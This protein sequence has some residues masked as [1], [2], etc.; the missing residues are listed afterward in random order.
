MRLQ[1]GLTS[2]DPP[3]ISNMKFAIPAKMRFHTS[4]Q[5]TP[6]EL[7]SLE[8]MR[9]KPFHTA[10][11]TA[12]TFLLVGCASVPSGVE[13]GREGTIAYQVQIES[14]D[15]GARVEANGDYVG[16]TPM[17]LKIFG[18]KDGTFHNF[19]TDDYVIR[20]YPLKPGQHPQARSFRTGRWFSQEDR[21][22]GRLYFDLNEK[23]EG[24]SID[25]PPAKKDN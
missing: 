3:K 24:F 23:S 22:P 13:H 7:I 20:V 17:V 25:L 11:A 14:S 15:P 9:N 8:F 18:D 2:Y 21:I 4:H 19:G 1:I 12:A 10:L 5:Q 16:N 6:E